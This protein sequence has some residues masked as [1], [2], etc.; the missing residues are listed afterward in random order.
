MCIVI[1]SNTVAALFDP[2]NLEHA[3]LEPVHDWIF[4]GKGKVVYGGT[5]YRREVFERQRRY[6]GLFEELRRQR[7]VVQ[8]PTDE[9][10]RAETRIK[11]AEPSPD[12]DDA[13]LLAIHD[14]SGC[15]L[16]CSK[17]ARA[18]RFLKK[19]TL[20]AHG[21]PPRIYRKAKDHRALLCD[22]N[23]APC[24]QPDTVLGRAQREALSA[25]PV[26]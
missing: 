16:L 22:D 1:D 14:I 17:D 5:T 12:F 26:R 21:G 4:K 8:A 13:H 7:K 18:D 15:L 2:N 20:Y 11:A 9:V 25:V 19:R 23:I 10:D 3:E 6:N 24:C